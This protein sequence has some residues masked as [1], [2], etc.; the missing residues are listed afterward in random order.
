MI[1]WI[2]KAANRFAAWMDDVLFP[3]NVLCLCCDHALGAEDTDGI[4]AACALALDRLADMQEERERL[5]AGQSLPAGLDY[6]HAAYPY[7]EQARTLIRQL[8]Y[9]SV[10]AA[11]VPLAARMAYLSSGEEAQAT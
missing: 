8:K 10:R 11:A 9:K 5:E 7:E 6:V 2:A 3:Q 1:A 4:C